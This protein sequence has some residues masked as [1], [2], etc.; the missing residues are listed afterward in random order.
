MDSP[1]TD[2][3]IG[4]KLL[5]IDA[6]RAKI[7]H[8]EA[9]G[10]R[11]LDLWNAMLRLSRGNPQGNP[12]FLPF[13]AVMTD[14]SALIAEAKKAVGNYLAEAEG[15]GSAGYLFNIW[16]FAFPH[17]RWALW[18]DFMRRAGYYSKDE[19]DE[20]AAKFLCIQFRDN[21]A[22]LR[23]KP[24]PECVDNQTAS[25]V[26]A[27][28]LIGSLFM[29]GPGEGNLA[30]LLCDAAA[31]RLEA[32]IGGMPPSG[33]GGEGS[34]YQGRIVA[35]A[36]PLLLEALEHL[37]GEDLF[38]TPLATRGA[39]AA[40]V[41]RSTRNLWLPGG[42][43]LPWDDYGWQFGIAFP[44]AYLAARTGD[45]LCSRMLERDANWSR[46]N[47][48]GAGWGHDDPVWT[49]I[50][51]PDLP[52]GELPGWTPWR[53][54][55][56]GGTL[57]D[58]HGDTFLMQ[59]W[60]PTA[61]MCSRPHVNPNAIILSYKGI[62]FS[63]DG[64]DG[65]GSPDLHYDGAVF[66]RNFGAGA[67]QH[68]NL[69][70]GCAGSHSCLL[71]DGDQGF[72]PKS[73]GYVRSVQAACVD[74][75]DPDT[76]AGDVTGLYASAYP[77]ALSV[78]RRS[79]LIGDRFWLI[80]DYASFADEHDFTARWW[81]RP[82]VA[83]NG[84]GIDLRTG[85]GGLLQMRPLLESG[86]PVVRHVTGFPTWPDNASD[87]VDFP[88]P[89]GRKVRG[90]WLAWPALAFQATDTLADGWTAWPC[91]LDAVP[92]APAPANA[93]HDMPPSVLPWIAADAPTVNDW[94]F[95][96]AVTIPPNSALRLPRGLDT[97]TRLWIDGYEVDISPALSTDLV[98][99][100]L[101]LDGIVPPGGHTLEL[102]VSYPTRHTAE[103][104]RASNPDTPMQIGMIADGPTIESCAFD[105][106]TV[107][108][109]TTDGRKW[110]FG[111][112]L[113]EDLP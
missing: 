95:R 13:V 51:W 37:R 112:A 24:D 11:R 74:P 48:S 61:P 75:A 50:Y 72:R 16:C 44:L 45:P 62:P 52:S 97:T 86:E 101:P 43:L 108:L 84:R 88:Y 110:I 60:D 39:S 80:E 69:S 78:R 66:D 46:F 109:A 4:E 9:T 41:L 81:F 106:E 79:T 98:T 29:D 73:E 15:K 85:D 107:T 27:S 2:C 102:A 38:E 59:M 49:L 100:L 105:G 57:V 30:R 18:F 103:R 33:Y 31:P 14:D 26:L 87:R 54:P 5:P 83:A 65:E 77:D 68:M 90:L 89:R 34:T 58:P 67:A 28:Y 96:H 7:A 23:V 21:L 93:R 3:T 20:I 76:I 47:G 94:R 36:I 8:I 42:L 99:P 91:P 64:S 12:W 56:L 55:S 113:M 22:G 1:R 70:K 82:G 35:F 92:G 6:L 63:A 10:G 32:M 53:D 111:Y 17:C 40:S 25:L 19:A 104:E 71:V